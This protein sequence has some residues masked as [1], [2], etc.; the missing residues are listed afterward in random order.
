[1]G[2]PITQDE[3]ATIYLRQQQKLFLTALSYT[4]SMYA[5][6]EIVGDTIV[7]AL[8]AKVTFDNEAAC[9]CYMRAVVR[10]KAIS[11]LRRK[12]T[13]EPEEGESLE[14]L[15]IE[16]N[17]QERSYREVELQLLI[18]ELLAE[19]PKEVREAFI[20]HV[21]DREPIPQLAV[22]YGIKNDTLRKQ[23]Q[24]MKTK[25]AEAIP[26]KDMQTF[27]FLLLLYS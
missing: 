22:L 21:L 2:K 4:D 15:L 9:A 13:I 11:C 7:A 19:Y 5:A 26:E 3:I 6:E 27:L 10:N 1:V 12:Y 24:R 8:E 25:I 20:A 14:R 23:I 16:H 17:E 18:Q